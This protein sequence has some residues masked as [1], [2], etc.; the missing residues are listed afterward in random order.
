MTGWGIA[1]ALAVGDSS[2]PAATRPNRSVSEPV[3]GVD[4]AASLWCG[5]CS[6]VVPGGRR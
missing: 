5:W 6:A 3:A 2:G 4:A 1:V